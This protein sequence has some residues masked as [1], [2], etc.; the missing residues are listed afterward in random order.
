M[1][2][3]QPPTRLLVRL[4]LPTVGIA[5]RVQQP[6][7]ELLHLWRC[8]EMCGEIVGD[9]GRAWEIVGRC[10]DAFNTARASRRCGKAA[11]WKGSLWKRALWKG[12]AVEWGGCGMGLG[13]DTL[14]V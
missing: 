5:R 6:L 9:R 1:G 3:L 4:G 14:A 10:G 8:G 12:A 13:G 7:E 11:L 2:E